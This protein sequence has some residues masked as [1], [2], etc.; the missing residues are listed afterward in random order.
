MKYT[1]ITEL[2]R[3]IS[4]AC[5]VLAVC[6]LVV[7]QGGYF[8]LPTC[9][10]G[11]ILCIAAGIIWLLRWRRGAAPVSHPPV[12]AI[13]LVALSLV[14]LASALANGLTLTTLAESGSWIAYAGVALLA[15]TQR[16]IQRYRTVVMIAWLGVATAVLGIVEYVG[17]LVIPGGMMV[18][19]LQFTFQ[20]ANATAVWYGACALLCLLILDPHG[21]L[22][23][24]SPLPVAAILLTQSAGGVIS[25]LVVALAV[26]VWLARAG[27][28]DEL[29]CCLARGALGVVLFA[30]LIAISSPVM[31]LAVVPVGYASLRLDV[32]LDKLPSRFSA[33][34][35]CLVL[36]AAL[37]LFL[38]AIPLLLPGRTADAVASLGE[39]AAILRDALGL[40]STKPF[41]GIGPDNWQYLFPWVQTA[42]YSVAVVHSSWAQ[43]LTDAGLVGFGVLIAVFVYGVRGLLRAVKAGDAWSVACLAAAAL[44]ILHSAFDFDL[45]F[46]ALSCLLAFLVSVPADGARVVVDERPDIADEHFGDVMDGDDASRPAVVDADI[47]NQDTNKAAPVRSRMALAMAIVSLAVCLPLAAAGLAC[48]LTSEALERGVAAGAYEDVVALF[49]SSRLCISDPKAQGEYVEASFA[50]EH[51][52]AVTDAYEHVPAPSVATTLYAAIAYEWREMPERAA[53]ALCARL[54][55]TPYDAQIVAGARRFDETFGMDE[56]YRSRFDGALT[57]AERLSSGG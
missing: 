33:R 21:Y 29:L 51:F 30:T 8:G 15:A 38:V 7:A 37:A 50:L 5:V 41:L 26:G 49:R 6:A 13:L 18:G 32:L 22:R 39:R 20:Y 52:A 9:I 34:T 57:N 45:Q 31:L 48:S 43:A 53:E 44:L 2:S 28:W 36:V 55:A 4:N 16:S 27:R 3:V 19:R 40:W 56:A 12:V 54:E 11:T 42:P 14:Y 25:F 35:C 24:C 1:T 47:S 17:L 23:V 46:G 10:V